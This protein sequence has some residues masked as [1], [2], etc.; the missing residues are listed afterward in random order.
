MSPKKKVDR[1]RA[2]KRKSVK[3]GQ[4]KHCQIC[5]KAILLTAEL[6]S[7]ECK[8]QFDTIMRRRKM[9]MYLIYGMLILFIILFIFTIGGGGSGC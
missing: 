2:E 8:K 4:H 1:A 3:I 5:G 7:D 9:Y 6:C